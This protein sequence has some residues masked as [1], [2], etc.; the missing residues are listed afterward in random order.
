[1]ELTAIPVAEAACQLSASDGR[2]PLDHAL[3]DGEDF[4][5]VL[6]VPPAQAEQILHD[7]PLDVSISKIGQI[8]D[9]PGL[10]RLDSSG[11]RT[12]LDP[13]GFQHQADA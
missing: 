8:V 9:S 11:Q 1:M 12:K 3:S 13:R 2:S 6:A 7:Q 5:L 4:E 10:W